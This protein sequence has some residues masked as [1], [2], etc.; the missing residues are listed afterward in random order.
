MKK[1]NAVNEPKIVK[2][3][4]SVIVGCVK[5]YEQVDNK[6]NY[7]LLVNDPND[8]IAKAVPN[9]VSK[10]METVGEV[11][12]IPLN[13]KLLQVLSIN[14]NLPY[15]ET[16]EGVD[17][18]GLVALL[19]N[20]RYRN[21]VSFDVEERIVGVTEYSDPATGEVLTHKGSRKSEV[22]DELGTKYNA[23]VSAQISLSTTCYDRIEDLRFKQLENSRLVEVH[24]LGATRPSKPRRGALVTLPQGDDEQ[25][26]IPEQDEPKPFVFRERAAG[27]AKAEYNALKAKAE[28][29]WNLEQIKL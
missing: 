16:K 8:E 5:Q 6:D 1:E 20:P 10:K 29:Q 26:N 24:N 12:L 17:C 25:D 23:I 21:T 28:E 22:P 3:F 13:Q 18:T 19:Q 14:N 4:D 7:F 2:Q 15:A 27:E 9:A 11:V